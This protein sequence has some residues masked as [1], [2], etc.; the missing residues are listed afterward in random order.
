MCHLPFLLVVVAQWSVWHLNSDG[1]CRTYAKIV[2]PMDTIVVF[3][4]VIR[5]ANHPHVSEGEL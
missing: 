2:Q 3:S 4:I 1:L 5:P